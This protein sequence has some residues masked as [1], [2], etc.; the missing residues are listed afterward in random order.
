MAIWRVIGVTL[1]YQ[2]DFLYN[3]MASFPITIRLESW[4]DIRPG[5]SQSQCLIICSQMLRCSDSSHSVVRSKLAPHDQFPSVNTAL[6]M[7]RLVRLFLLCLNDLLTTR[8]Y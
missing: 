3:D 5:V 2:I 7:E 1:V 8:I 4:L 6:C